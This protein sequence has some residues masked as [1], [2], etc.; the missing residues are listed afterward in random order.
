MEIQQAVCVTRFDQSERVICVVIFA[1]GKSRFEKCMRWNLTLVILF[2]ELYLIL[3]FL[4]YH[5]LVLVRL[6][7]KVN[8]SVALMRSSKWAASW[9][10]PCWFHCLCHSSSW[11]RSYLLLTVFAHY[12]GQLGSIPFLLLKFGGLPGSTPYSV[13]VTSR[14]KYRR[15]KRSCKPS[16][17]SPG[18]VDRDESRHEGNNI[19][20]RKVLLKFEPEEG[21]KVNFYNA[22]Q[23]FISLVCIYEV[24]A[25]YTGAV[26]SELIFIIQVFFLSRQWS[27]FFFFVTRHKQWFYL[28]ILT[29]KW[30]AKQLVQ[31]IVGTVLCVILLFSDNDRALQQLCT[32]VPPVE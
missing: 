17:R 7:L 21:K 1:L 13:F 31:A 9:K 11:T 24:Q 26:Q 18:R 8:V 29:I 10:P 27:C 30:W 28:Y 4:E 5:I 22:F 15:M 19:K 16:S 6:S 23:R 2:S 12:R 32:S 3:K 14:W 25:G 20:L